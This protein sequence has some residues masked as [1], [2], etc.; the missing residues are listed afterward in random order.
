MTNERSEIG[1]QG[2]NISFQFFHNAFAELSISL[3]QEYML[4]KVSKL[5]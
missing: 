3:K 4:L 5:K 2:R 1:Q